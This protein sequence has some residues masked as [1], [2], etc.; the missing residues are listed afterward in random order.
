M[1]FSTTRGKLESA[2][3][4]DD[5]EKAEVFEKTHIGSLG[6]FYSSGFS[7]KFISFEELDQ[8]FIRIHEVDG[9]LCCGKATFYYYR[10]V[11]VVNGKEITDIMSE[12]EDILDQA[13][14]AIARKAPD[15]KIGK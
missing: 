13:L 8:A 12:N 10:L 3:L 4:S 5:Y 14:A 2:E 6:V 11:L 15:V 1:K 7:I 9:K